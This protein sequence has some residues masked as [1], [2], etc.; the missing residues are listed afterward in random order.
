MQSFTGNRFDL[1]VDVEAAYAAKAGDAPE[2][3]ED[4]TITKRII[5]TSAFLSTFHTR[6]NFS[7]TARRPHD[8]RLWPWCRRRQ[9]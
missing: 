6:Q 2:R 3:M 7:L 4:M 8:A 9:V 1:S 5:S